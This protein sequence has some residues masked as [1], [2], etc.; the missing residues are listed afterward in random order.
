MKRAEDAFQRACA[1]AAERSRLA[2]LS[3]EKRPPIR[4]HEIQTKRGGALWRRS[5]Q[6]KSALP[7]LLVSHVDRRSRKLE[8]VSGDKRVEKY[9]WR[10]FA[11]KARRRR[12]PLPR[13]GAAAAAASVFEYDVRAR[14]GR[15]AHASS[16]RCHRFAAWALSARAAR[17]G[18]GFLG[19][20]APLLLDLAQP[21]RAALTQRRQGRGVLGV[22]LAQ[23]ARGLAA[24][25]VD[26]R[27]GRAERVDATVARRGVLALERRG[28][29]PR[30]RLRMLRGVLG[31]ADVVGRAP[32]AGLG[33]ARE[34]V[35]LSVL[36]L[37]A[38]APDGGGVVVAG[39][40]GDARPGARRLQRR[41]D[42]PD[43][44][45]RLLEVRR[46]V[47]RRL[48]P[49]RDVLDGRRR[50]ERPAAG[51]RQHGEAVD[52]HLVGL[53]RRG[54]V[55]RIARRRPGLARVG[56]RR[57]ARARDVVARKRVRLADAAR[58][59]LEQL[60]ELVQLVAVRRVAARELRGV[61]RAQAREAARVRAVL[62]AR[63]V[64]GRARRV[65]E[66]ARG[67]L[68]GARV[69]LRGGREARRGVVALAP[70]GVGRGARAR[71]ASARDAPAA[72]AA[73]RAA[74]TSAAASAR[75]ASTC[76]AVSRVSEPAA[77]AAARAAASSS[78]KAARAAASSSAAAC[79]RAAAS[80]A[81]TAAAAWAAATAAAL[82]A[83]QDSTASATAS[84]TA[85]CIAD[86]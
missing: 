23:V 24:L 53:R 79:S 39:D 31:A 49:R 70:R 85:R 71:S 64:R 34:R 14:R 20:A 86:S 69:R 72:A 1:A 54:D 5:Q 68:V 32:E 42:G 4:R 22:A 18:A 80:A 82:S 44:R 26:G 75:A 55:V 46:V 17:R 52:V 36:L 21:V 37:A 74:A 48:Q 3:H 12:G 51:P 58:L 66:A 73:L 67:G 84:T 45:R 13:R 56:R 83:S 27:A 57:V 11:K 6:Q 40:D 25:L 60:A 30:L 65:G 59:L 38:L 16:A 35:E 63:G 81:A 8:R 76:A 10:R 61:G 47:G 77:D 43:R 62:L 28:G 15:R 7:R 2:R 41:H 19:R 78:A 33:L 50:L 29:A 9:G